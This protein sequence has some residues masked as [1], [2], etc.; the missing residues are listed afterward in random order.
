MRLSAEWERR[1]SDEKDAFYA[2][3]DRE[4]DENGILVVPGVLT[5]E[6]CDHYTE[7]LQHE[8]D[9]ASHIERVTGSNLKGIYATT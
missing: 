4:L 7:L 1:S 8:L 3:M 9:T 2:E 5:P 6:Q